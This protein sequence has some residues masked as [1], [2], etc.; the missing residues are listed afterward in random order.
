MPTLAD[1][2]TEALEVLG[3]LAEGQAASNEDEEVAERMVTT[4]TEWLTATGAYTVIDTTDI[5]EAARYPLALMVS[6]DL[7]PK[8][9]SPA[10]PAG[11]Q[12]WLAVRADGLRRLQQL[13]PPRNDTPTATYF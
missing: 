13:A 12:S 1:I 8:F 2:A 11:Y 6:A 5:A 4:V 9:S 3:V 7:A 10:P